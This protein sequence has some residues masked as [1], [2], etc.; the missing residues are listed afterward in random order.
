MKIKITHPD[1]ESLMVLQV[2]VAGTP[3]GELLPGETM[4]VEGPQ[5]AVSFS[6]YIEEKTTIGSGDV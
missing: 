2:S 5:V 3:H 1:P 6:H 4:E